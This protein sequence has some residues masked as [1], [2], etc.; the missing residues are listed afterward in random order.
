MFS[1]GV[2]V[3]TGLG[4]PRMGGVLKS[5]HSKFQG[6]ASFAGCIG[7]CRRVKARC[8][9]YINLQMPILCARK[10]YFNRRS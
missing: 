4:P 8:V 5:R 1:I 2:I 3:C 7:A 6:D 9:G 10:E